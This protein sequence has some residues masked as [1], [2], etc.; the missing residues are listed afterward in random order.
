[1]T[2]ALP[3]KP[4]SNTMVATNTVTPMQMLQ[5]AVEQ[6]ADL[7]K[8]ERLMELERRW[9]SDKAR[10]A[11]HEALTAFKSKPVLVTK[12]K[13]NVQYGSMYTSLSNLVNKVNQYCSE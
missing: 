13:H 10:E 9:K 3:D 12:D 6:G 7:D 5:M 2:K 11:F 1:M 8:M 4:K